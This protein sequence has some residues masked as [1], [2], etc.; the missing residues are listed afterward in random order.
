MV[1]LA[2]GGKGGDKHCLWK[3]CGDTHKFNI[4]YQND[5]VVDRRALGDWAHPSTL[6]GAGHKPSFQADISAKGAATRAFGYPFQKHHVIPCAVFKKLK[7]ISANLKLLGYDIN[8]EGLNGISLPSKPK[9]IKWHDLQAHRGPHPAYNNEVKAYLNTLEG[10]VKDFCKDDNQGELWEEIEDA[11]KNFR[12]HILSWSQP[13][14]RS[15]AAGE[16]ISAAKAAAKSF[17]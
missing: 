12:K 5:G 10:E 1:I 2:K 11:V 6:I 4:A 8:D 15:G 16:R 3:V 13:T 9:D 7:K 14:L 17:I